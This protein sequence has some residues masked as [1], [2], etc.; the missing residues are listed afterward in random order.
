MRTA[1]PLCAASEADSMQHRK[2]LVILVLAVSCLVLLAS[3]RQAQTLPSLSS[4]DQANLQNAFQMFAQ[5]RQ[6]FRF[7][8]FNDQAFWGDTLKLHQAI[9]GAKFGGVGPGVSPATALA[10]GL[11]VD[12][13]ALPVPLIAQLKQG[14][15]NLNDPAVTLALL[16]LNSVVGVTGIFNSDGSLKSV[17]IQCA[18][19]H[20]TVDNS[21]APGIGHRLDGWANRDLN[22]GEIVSLAPNLQPFAQ[23]LG[24]NQATVRKVLQS[25]GPG[26]FDAELALD[27]KAFRPDGKPSAVLIPPA[28]GLAGVN[29]H[30]WTGWGS[31]TYWNAFVANL[32]MHGQGTFFDPRLDN[33]KRFP[34]A[35]KAGFGHMSNVPDVITPQLAALHFYQL[36]IP[37]PVPPKGSFDEE[38][39]KRGQAIFNG[40]GKCSTCH[41]PPLYTEPG[42]NM[43]T[44]SEV[45][46]DSFQANRAPDRRFRTSPL[47]GLWT[48]TTGGFYHD[49]RFP[50]LLDVVNH[51]DSCFSLGLSGQDKTDLVEFLKSLPQPQ[52]SSD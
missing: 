51:Y 25:W 40:S 33:A 37:A 12:V 36:A 47:K 10:V 42:W 9:E 28:F 17:G 8:T 26:H 7:A 45:C 30:T 18:L 20:S 5:G 35:A 39:A 1:S 6:V 15:V 43:H 16:K 41:V 4:S 49:G 48:H 3:E 2:L 44:A 32:E 50:T 29:L 22:V 52:S 27:G 31:V 21:L 24:V 13:D 34:V 38:A 46:V 19:C 11:K 23:L 14:Q